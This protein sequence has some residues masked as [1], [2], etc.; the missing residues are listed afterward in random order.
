M[1]GANSPT[2][3][4]GV[5]AIH[6]ICLAL[7]GHNEQ[8]LTENHMLEAFWQVVFLS[9]FLYIQTINQSKQESC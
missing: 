9:S 3:P 5:S 6:N 7:V 2:T 1:Q 4:T 8:T